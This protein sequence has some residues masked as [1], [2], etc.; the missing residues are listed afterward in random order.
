MQQQ[1]FSDWIVTVAYAGST[2]NH[3]FIQNQLN[4]T[5]FGKAGATANATP[6]LRAVLHLDRGSC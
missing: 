2:G 5:V 4:P 3:L 6:P 1:V